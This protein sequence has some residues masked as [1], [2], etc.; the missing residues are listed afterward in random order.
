MKKQRNIRVLPREELE[1][2][3]TEALLGRLARLRS[4]EQS[5]ADSDLDP[6]E[7]EALHGINFKDEAEWRDA[8]MDLKAVLAT[9]EHVPRPAEQPPTPASRRARG[10]GSR[11]RPSR[12]SGR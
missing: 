12:P 4:L 2:L 11:R 3:P 1:A 7:L 5:A 10:S 9:R 6:H 8:Y